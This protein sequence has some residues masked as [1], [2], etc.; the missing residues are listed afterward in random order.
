MLDN[1]CILM[2]SVVGMLNDAVA[3]HRAGQLDGAER[4][5]REILRIDP[6]QPDAL[7]LM[8]VLAN[9]RGDGVVAVDWIRRSL[10]VAPH[11]AGAHYNL[12][13]ACESAGRDDEA[14]NA[15][16]AAL[17]LAPDSLDA[18]INLGRLL[19]ARGRL[20]EAADC[21]RRAIAV[22]PTAAKAHFN[23]ANALSRLGRADEALNHLRE[24]VRLEPENPS[25]HNNLGAALKEL[26]R[27][28]DAADAFRRALALAPAFAEAHNNL[29]SCLHFAGQLNEARTAFGR[30]IELDPN[31][32]GAWINLGN[33][34]SDENDIPAAVA[35]Y[36]RALQAEPEN[37]QARFNRALALLQTGD[38]TRGWA[39]YEWRFHSKV[40]KRDFP[41]PEWDGS[42]LAQK[43]ILV[44]AEQGIGD[45]IMFAGCLPDV[46]ATA[47]KCIIECDPRLVELFARSF[48]RAVVVA[49]D[50]GPLPQRCGSI[51]VQ[52]AMGSLCRYFRNGPDAF[53]SRN[54]YLIP[55]AERVRMWHTR[56]AEKGSG[57]KIGIS[58]RGGEEVHLRRKRSTQLAQ[59][60][61][62]LKL[63]G[64]CFVNLQYGDVAAELDHLAADT[65]CV[66]HRWPDADL[67]N[68][69][70]ALAALIASLDLV[71]SVDNSTVHLAG[72]LGK[73]VW[74]LLPFA[75]DWRWLLDRDD[76]PWYPTLRL[77]RQTRPGDWP[78]TISRA[79]DALRAKGLGESPV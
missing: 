32:A 71:I 35:C 28:D 49:R 1:R 24:A 14:E 6:Q 75:A 76:T 22:D 72:A 79:A 47:R 66:V 67:R 11:F 55:D 18:W 74:T 65:G 12:A 48:L 37:P 33:V 58:W 70:E 57:L 27:Y 51:D 38:F 19:A 56:L 45:E 44:H 53:P 34:C 15:Y 4:A 25:F 73:P 31:F 61:P 9:Q 36:E 64:A 77:F 20:D 41:F 10:A 59:W 78:G 69:L 30:A 8:G 26:G 43:T 2:P 60:A 62:I 68:D 42:D 54:G 40:R 39:E 63:P 7:H 16:R 21:Y 5:Y 46:I 23:L 17:R 52:S 50:A 13:M 29:G 3:L